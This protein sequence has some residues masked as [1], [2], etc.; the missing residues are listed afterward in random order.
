MSSNERPAPGAPLVPRL[1]NLVALATAAVSVDRRN[2]P[3]GPPRRGRGAARAARSLRAVAGARSRTMSASA[4][5]PRAPGCWE[6]I[7]A[8]GST[9]PRW[10]SS[11]HRAPKPFVLS[12][13]QRVDEFDGPAPDL[14]RPRCNRCGRRGVAGG[15]DRDAAR[16]VRRR[17]GGSLDWPGR[18]GRSTVFAV[19]RSIMVSDRVL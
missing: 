2:G 17:L 12:G 19:R 14:G 5:P 18:T 15:L 13:D 1:A 10:S 16:R 3:S 9:L 11:S 4:P 7:I 6:A 8:S